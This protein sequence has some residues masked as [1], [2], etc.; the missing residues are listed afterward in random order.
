MVEE[1]TVPL[2]PSQPEFVTQGHQVLPLL[3]SPCLFLFSTPF[4]RSDPMSGQTSSLQ[5]F[6]PSLSIRLLMCPYIPC[7]LGRKMFQSQPFHL[8]PSLGPKAWF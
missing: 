3:L 7:T 2:S 8:M 1:W 5:E 6:L 4:P